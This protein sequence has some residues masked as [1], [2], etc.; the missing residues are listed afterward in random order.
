MAYHFPLTRNA[1]RNRRI[2]Q[3]IRE[4]HGPTLFRLSQKKLFNHEVYLWH[5]DR[6]THMCIP[7]GHIEACKHQWACVPTSRCLWCRTFRDVFLCSL[8]CQH[9]NHVLR[10]RRCITSYNLLHQ[11]SNYLIRFDAFLCLDAVLC[12]DA[13]LGFD[14][15]LRFNSFLRFDPFIRCRLSPMR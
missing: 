12:L 9:M 2:H 11:P 14:A 1:E 15:S 6:L 5:L 10:S 13:F 7:F 3:F 4:R 8:A